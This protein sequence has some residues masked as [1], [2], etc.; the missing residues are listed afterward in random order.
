[1]NHSSS[2]RMANGLPHQARKRFGQNFLH[3]QAV[4][5]RIIDC[6]NPQADQHLLEIGPGQAALT[7]PLASSGAKL[8]CVELDRDLAAFLEKEFRDNSNVTIHQQDILK[9]DLH[10][11][12]PP[13]QPPHRIR[14]IGNL[15]YNISTPVMFHLLKNHELIADMV[16]MLQLEVVNRLAAKPGDKNYGRLGL[17]AQYYCQIDHLFNVPSAAFTPKPKVSSAIVRLTPHRE[18]PVTAKSVAC[19]QTVIRTAFN[20]RR[21]T[22]KNSLRNLI[23]VDK[24][25]DLPIDLGQRPETLSLA[26]FVMISD[27][28]TDQQPEQ[29]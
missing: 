1:M 17:M 23:S 28:L 8:D 4:I 27:R 14:I 6:I 10:A 25:I 22:L 24:L 19:L 20:Q 21:K 15:P 7:R 5:G 11:L 26:E 2:I 9:F 13:D 16:F 29:D 3:D 12:L 18:F